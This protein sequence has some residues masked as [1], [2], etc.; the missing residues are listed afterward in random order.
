MSQALDN[1]E[2]LYLRSA[3]RLL[4]MFLLLFSCVIAQAR[5]WSADDV[6][7]VHLQDRNR[8]VCDPD[9][10]LSDQA[11][12]SADVYLS[13]LHRACGVQTVFVIVNRVKDADC[14]RMAQ[15]IGNHYGVGT[16]KERRGLVVVIAVADRRY[17]IAPGKGLEADLTDVDCDDIA[18][19][20]IVRHMREDNTD[21]AVTETCKALFRKLSTGDAGTQ[22][23]DG[24]SDSSNNVLTL[25]TVLIFCFG[26]T[27]WAIIVYILRRLDII[28]R[29]PGNRRK[30]DDD[31][32][33]PPFLFGGGGGSFG[34]SGGGSFGGGSFGGGGS[35]GGW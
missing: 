5:V 26:S 11:R 4:A 1:H 35:G 18:R 19:A 32:W 22:E 29:K 3:S 30:R 13:R 20:C 25:I 2:P 23:E 27:F 17:F 12:D 33:M 7:M 34:G 21:E 8:Y 24:D 9:G 10:I 28:K 6:P 14:F 16:R 15:D 31:D